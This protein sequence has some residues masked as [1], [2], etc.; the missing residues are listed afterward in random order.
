MQSR[1]RNA[2]VIGAALSITSVGAMAQQYPDRA[3]RLIIPFA[4]AGTNDIIGRVVAQKASELL[5]QPIVADNRAGAGG[6]I[7][8]TLAARSQPDGYT[9]L[10]GHI[11]TLAV[12]PT[13]YRKPG[14]DPLTDFTPITLVAKLPNL[15]AVFPKLP[16]KTVQE[17]VALAKAK[18]GGLS[19]GS[20]GVGGAAH[21]ATE[22][23]K[24]QTG[25][26][27]VHVAYRGTGLAVVDVISGQLAMTMAG[28]PAIIPHVRNGNLRAMAVTGAQ[29]SRMLPDLPT[30]AESGVPGFEA[31]QWYG[32]VTP[33]GAPKTVLSTLHGA[34]V[35]A[36]QSPEVSERFAADGAEP[37]TN[38]PQEFRAYIKAEIDRWAPIV[39]AIGQ[40]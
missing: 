10:L 39:R 36:V 17:F 13:L 20:G 30:V 33:A 26:D 23:F 25:I 28:I 35:K 22:Y 15:M 29:R 12:N 1:R 5:G 37:F 24:Q 14:Y 2:C 3:I 31:T 40:Q 27:I 34:I 11:G 6:T 9:L 4:P 8:S 19:Y 21:L 32:I 18:K 38:S 7:G 16:S